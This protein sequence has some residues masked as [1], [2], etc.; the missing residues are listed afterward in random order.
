MTA[1]QAQKRKTKRQCV[2]ELASTKQWMHKLPSL[3]DGAT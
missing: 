2:N 3:I 1:T